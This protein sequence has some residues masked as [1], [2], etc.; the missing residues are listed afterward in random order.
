M[1]NYGILSAA[2]SFPAVQLEVRV[3][4]ELR[5]SKGSSKLNGT[6]DEVVIAKIEA[7]KAISELMHYEFS[8]DL[9]EGGRRVAKTARSVLNGA[10]PEAVHNDQYTLDLFNEAIE[11]NC[12]EVAP[13][14][15]S[16]Q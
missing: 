8:K 5:D 3:S 1:V 16:S 6:T 2:L 12:V 11:M 7:V 4:V 10:H 15:G 14:F 9:A 13:Y